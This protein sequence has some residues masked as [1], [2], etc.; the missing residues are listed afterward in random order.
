MSG[1]EQEAF[2]RAVRSLVQKG[3]NRLMVERRRDR[4]D[5][6]GLTSLCKMSKRPSAP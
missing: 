6:Q 1:I 5:V 4:D 3:V 2:T